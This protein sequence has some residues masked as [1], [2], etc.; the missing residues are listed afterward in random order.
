MKLRETPFTFTK[1]RAGMVLLAL[2]APVLA[3]QVPAGP[4][5]AFQDQVPGRHRG[6]I[7][8]LIHRGDMV[9]SAGEDGFLE[10][11]DT[12]SGAAA[13]RLQLSPYRITALAGRP[14]TDEICVVESDGLGLYRISAW[15]YRERR[16]L[17]RL[18][19]GDPVGY[20]D[21]SAAGNFIIAALSGGAVPLL[22]D[23]QTG[24]ARGGPVAGTV[25]F[26]ATGRSERTM[27]AYLTAGALCYWD[28]ETGAETARFDAPPQL[29]SLTGF[30]NSRYLAGLG[31]AGLTVLDAASGAALAR[32][33]SI[34]PDALLAADGDELYC[35][36]PSAAGAVLYRFAVDRA[37]QIITRERSFPGIGADPLTAMAAQ[38]TAALGNAGGGLVLIGRNGRT[39]EL[40]FREQ[41]RIT[42]TAVSGPDLAFLTENG[43]LGFLPLEYSRLAAGEPL[44]LEKSGGYTRLSPYAGAGGGDEGFVLWQAENTRIL[45]LIRSPDRTG[46]SQSLTEAASAVPLRAVS[47]AEGKLLFL[48]S[49]GTVSV[50]ALTTDAAGAPRQ[51]R[52]FSFSTIGAMDAAFTGGDHI[53][54]GRSAVS[55]NSPFL[56][57]NIATGETVPL[58][59]S[60]QAGAMVYA[61]ESGAIYGAAIDQA[62]GAPRTV[63]V[64]LDNPANPVRL[65]E[66]PGEDTQFSLAEAGG[67]LAATIGGEGAARYAEGETAP[68]ERTPG[69]PLRLAG[70]GRFFISLD[71][72][73][74]LCWHESRTGNL[75]AVFRLH[76]DEWTL[77]A[78]EETL[79]G[80]LVE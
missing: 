8:A 59:Y 3:A 52:V 20:I 54:I 76:R 63:I 55:R 12:V 14:G 32:E 75:R 19:L 7:T 68:F 21:Y 48:D 30:A 38:G 4:D 15:N 70:G 31:P 9:L 53:L 28:L 57:I 39:R 22:I 34:G 62:E 13:E 36:A 41:V 78:G 18:D 10:I 29:V 67:F 80:P 58:P 71:E 17:F 40:A 64:R 42:E 25:G 24:R 23:S 51:R 79:S 5:W 73:G 65:A 33:P 49:A 74:N 56:M 2:L 72:E 66:L 44:Y 26:A 35:L 11:W 43:A 27:L 1:R 46:G 47:A 61:G 37:G 6:R 60:S 45:P 50:I 77:Q 16:R 69:L